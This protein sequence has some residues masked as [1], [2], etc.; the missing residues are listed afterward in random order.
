MLPSVAPLAP[1]YVNPRYL[2]RYARDG[3]KISSSVAFL[4]LDCLLD[5]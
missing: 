4:A 5:V 2:M 1:P 3:F